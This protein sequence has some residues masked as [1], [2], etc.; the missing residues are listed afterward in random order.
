M[1]ETLRNLFVKRLIENIEVIAP[2]PRF[3]RFGNAY[4]DFYLGVPLG[5]RGLNALGN[6]VGHTV[7]TVSDQGHVAAEYTIDK[8]YFDGD[9]DKARNDFEHARKKHPNA[10]DVFLLCTETA[11]PKRYSEMVEEAAKY[12]AKHGVSIHLHDGR[13]IAE[14]IV[15]RLLGNDAVVERLGEYLPALGQIRDEYEA[16]NLVP[17]PG[18]GY[19]ARPAVEKAVADA[20]AASSCVKVAGMG[21]SGKSQCA[22]AVAAA[23]RQ[24][25]DLI[26][27]CDASQLR[28]LEQLA[29]LPVARSGVSRN[30]VALLRT[31]RCLLVLD[32]ARVVF[33]RARVVGMCG[34]GSKVLITTR[35]ADADAYLIP[36]LEP[37]DAREMLGSGIDGGCPAEVFDAVWS[38][39]GGH[40]L[41]L[42]LMNAAVS[43]RTASWQELVADCQAVAEFVDDRQERIADRI[44]RRLMPALNR[45]LSL[46]A[47]AG[48]PTCDR[49]FARHAIQP[50][51]LR[52]LQT[53]CLTTPDAGASVRI[54]DIVY[55]CLGSTPELLTDA[56][57]RELGDAF[58]AYIRSVYSLDLEL[59]AVCYGMKAVLERLVR[60]GDR[61]PAFLYCLLMGWDPAEVDPAL[62]G[63]IHAYAKSLGGVQSPEPI[64]ISV[65][66]EAIEARYR[67]ERPSSYDTAKANLLSALPIFDELAALTG[68][69]DRSQTEI[70]HH[71][72][73]ALKLVG[74]TTEAIKVFEAVLAG[75]V[76]LQA[77]RLQLVRM[78]AR[79]RKHADRAQQL[80]SE[81][82]KTAQQK[83]QE[84]ASSIV[85]GSIESLSGAVPPDRQRL[86]YA[87]HGDMIEERILTSAMVGADQAYQAF[88]VIGRYWAWN[89]PQRFK[90]VFNS[91]PR[92]SVADV[93]RDY[94][95]SAYGEI[96]LEIGGDTDIPQ[97]ERQIMLE[98]SLGF[99]EAIEKPSPFQLR[100]MGEVLVKLSKWADAE[101]VLLP[102]E[103]K[104]EPW[105]SYWLAKARLGAGKAQDALQA[106]DAGL[107]K[108]DSSSQ[109]LSTFKA[110]RYDIRVDL[111]DSGAIDDLRE[112]AASCT[113]DR[114]K[115]VLMQRLAAA[116]CAKPA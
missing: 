91:L 45:E 50:V 116:E 87:D 18:N 100:K 84:V 96:L 74:E 76:P 20:L 46:F 62:M 36:P 107:Q 71:R 54:H 26:I 29:S 52:K 25:Y 78:Y 86:I 70:Q 30:V 104:Q 112:A 51:G 42:R 23:Q 13:R 75:P 2:G 89:E 1:N 10:K 83:P 61:R 77:A 63:D 19:L 80:V 44:L 108:L 97:Q 68:L 7:D 81:I 92:R 31:M 72:G 3:E 82:L 109:Y 114:Y 49:G 8:K 113:N 111:G 14:T 67:H 93:T 22:A 59:V 16:S 5:H 102:L 98:D 103:A 69:T 21:G 106:V 64:A 9:M 115:A 55:S 34:T 79:E 65:A 85:L 39:I 27:W 32:D 38:T 4:V 35:Q 73:K 12:R 28:H 105:R 101:A 15:D 110:L 99:F 37:E 90:S 48:Q 41:T 95:R 24:Q 66:L 94:D 58:E 40:P 47:W 17:D 60:A 6:P 53:Y 43:D 11:G 57:Q 56:R 88:A 33:D